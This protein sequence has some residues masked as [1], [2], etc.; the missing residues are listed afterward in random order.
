M[1]SD[2]VPKLHRSWLSWLIFLDRLAPGNSKSSLAERGF[3]YSLHTY[4]D[5]A[6]K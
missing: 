1:S 2:Q 6:K 4:Y 3:I 5:E